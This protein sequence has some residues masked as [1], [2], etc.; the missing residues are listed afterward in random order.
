MRID[1]EKGFLTI[2]EVAHYIDVKPKTFYAHL[3]EIPHYRIGRLIRFRRE[4]I[5]V[6]MASNRKEATP[7]RPAPKGPART[8]ANDVDA[9]VRKAIDQITG[10]RYTPRGK[11]DP[12]IEGL[13]KEG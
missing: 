9:I 13:K 8:S 2:N 6:W 5:D 4:D 7:A 3:S 1:E 11:S 12:D 10:R